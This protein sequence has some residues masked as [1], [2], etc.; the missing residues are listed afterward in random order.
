VFTDKNGDVYRRTE[1]GWQKNDGKGW[2]NLP[3]TGSR[4][5]TKPANANVA[6]NRKASNATTLS[7]GTNARQSN[8][9]QRPNSGYSTRSSLERQNHSRDRAQ[10]RSRQYSG[11]RARAGGARRR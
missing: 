5:G 3:S 7:A 4:E 1:G 10:A 6:S 2:S 11:S 9:Y 8:A